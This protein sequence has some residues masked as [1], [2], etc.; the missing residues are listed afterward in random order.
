MTGY[1]R[2]QPSPPR[3]RYVYYPNAADVPEAVGAR[4]SGRSYTIAAGAEGNLVFGPGEP[5]LTRTLDW[6]DSG[7]RELPL[8]GFKQISDVH[9]IDE[10]SPGRVEFFDECGPGFSSAWRPQEAASLHVGEM[11]LRR[12]RRIRRGPA[13]ETPLRVVIS[14]GDNVDNNQLNETRR[15]PVTRCRAAGRD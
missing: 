3:D 10:Q 4:I 5:H 12:L 9:A 7:G 6:D 14:T 11:M 1:V 15:R 13:T 2:P 8:A